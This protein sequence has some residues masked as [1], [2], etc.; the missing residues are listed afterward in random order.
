MITERDLQLI[1][2][3]KNHTCA[4][5]TTLQHFF[6][7]SKLVAQRRLK[8]L[9]DMNQIKRC[10]EYINEDYCYYLKK[11]KQLKHSVMITDFYRE[12]SKYNQIKYLQTQKQVGDIRPDGIFGYTDRC[13]IKRIAVLEVELSNKGFDYQKYRDFNF[14]KYFNTVPDV[15][16]AT[17]QKV[18][19]DSKINFIQIIDIQ[20]DLLKIFK[21]PQNNNKINKKTHLVRNAFT[22]G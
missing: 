8:C 15:Y 12:F 6:Y 7:P 18:K 9:Y 20:N 13:G 17:K 5:T 10:Q 11:P 22:L 19:S 4:T 2:W 1:E 21:Q 3:L 16:I 14:I